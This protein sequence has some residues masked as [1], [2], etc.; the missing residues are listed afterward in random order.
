MTSSIEK[1][2]LIEN[3]IK[4][5]LRGHHYTWIEPY[6]APKTP[7]KVICEHHHVQ[8]IVPYTIV[9]KNKKL[10]CR[11]C[12]KRSFKT[13]QCLFDFLLTLEIPFY[14]QYLFPWTDK[15]YRYDFV[16]LDKKIILELDGPQH[17]KQVHHWTSPEKT[18]EMD[19]EKMAFALHHGFTVIRMVQEEIYFNKFPWKPILHLALIE[20]HEIPEILY[21]TIDSTIYKNHT[22]N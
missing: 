9:K 18:Q 7:W 17:F 14:C 12:K 8:S 22:I 19:R 6:E 15:N 3:E 2:D 16:F 13:E 20:P 4:A 11:W 10:I 1:M 5:L 21:L